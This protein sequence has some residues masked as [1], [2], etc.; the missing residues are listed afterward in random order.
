MTKTTTPTMVAADRPPLLRRLAGTLPILLVCAL[1]A[2]PAALADDS[3]WQL[4]GDLRTSL[5]ESGPVT[6][7]FRQTYVPA[8]FDDGDTESGH[9][10]IWLPR[11]LRWN[12]EE[13][14]NKS[15]LLCEDEVWS[16]T[17]ME[18]GGS[19]YLIEPEEEV[20]LDLLLV[21][22]DSLRERYVAESERRPDGTYTIALAL[23]PSAESAF[24]AQ[25]HF[26]PVAKRVVGLETVDEEGNRTLFE[27]SD[28]ETLS[29]TA[30]FQPPK[31]IQWTE[32]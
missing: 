12:Y 27:V 16:W 28:Y 24:S 26:D 18:P 10:S 6:G 23:P 25:I 11:C 8:G 32:E 22:V 9:L 15:F 30:L 5:E 4:L 1:L 3:P 14:E 21:D 13:P 17:S 2:S 20:G 7:K 29:H 19:H 31:D